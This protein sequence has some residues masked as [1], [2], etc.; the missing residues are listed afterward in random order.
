[1]KK[2]YVYYFWK[3]YFDQTYAV[4]VI[5][6]FDMFINYKTNFRSSVL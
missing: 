2:A 3:Q 5:I 1:M 6:T 4:L